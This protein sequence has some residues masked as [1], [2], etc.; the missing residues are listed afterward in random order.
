MEELAKDIYLESGYPGVVLGAFV[1]NDGLL[2]VDSPFRMEDQRIWRTTLASLEKG[3]NRMLAMLDPHIDRT[4]GIRA[5][6]AT[7]IGHENSVNILQNRPTSAR[8]QDIDAGADWELFELPVNIRWVVPEMVFSHSLSIYFGGRPI[9]FTHHP[10]SHRAGIWIQDDAEKV[11]FVGDSV[12]L[13]QPPFLAWSD[14]D[15]WL[16]DLAL[17]ESETYR[18]YKVVS[19]RNGVVRTR[20]ITK[21]QE[22]LTDVQKTMIKAAGKKNPVESLIADVPRL[23]KILNINKALADLYHNRLAWGVEQ[24]FKN[25][26]LKPEDNAKGEN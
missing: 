22:F 19:G 4:L 20:S 23:L 7:V 17:L 9:Q 14:I 5:M 2:M 26:Y 13:H 10:G 25:H 8:S 18:G 15:L 21:L 1:F 12:I 24:Y 3:N 16:K 11:L 6:E